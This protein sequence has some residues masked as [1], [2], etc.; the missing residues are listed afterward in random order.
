MTKP[1]PVPLIDAEP[2]AAV[3]RTLRLAE[4]GDDTFRATSLP[5]IRR[6]YGGQV[7]AQALLAAAATVD[8]QRLP[9]SLHAYFLRGGKPE[10]SFDLSVDRLLDGRSFSN[11]HVTCAQEDREILSLTAS[12]QIGEAGTAFLEKMPE[13]PE[14]ESLTS[15]L[16]I[17]RAIDHPVAKFLGKTAA[18]DVRHVQRSLYTGADK[19]HSP[20]QQLWMKPRH[21]LPQGMPQLLHRTLLAYVIDQVM[22]EPAL[23]ATGLSWLTPGMSLASLDHSM[24]FHQDLDINDWMLFSGATSSVGGGRAKCQISVFRPDGTLAATAAQEGMVRVPR[25]D[26]KGSGRWGFE[27]EA[28]TDSA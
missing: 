27:G 19:E 6:V 1:V 9:H 21:E 4:T 5:Q 26:A 10:I 12:F 28:A 3:L 22:L 25:G 8:E 7:V 11:R 15:A 20:T 13:V 23:R 17:F 18:F 2:V 16:E 24:W 14:P